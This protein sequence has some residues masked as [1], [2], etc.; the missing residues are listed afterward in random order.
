MWQ[1]QTHMDEYLVSR[2]LH[3]GLFNNNIFSRTN[4]TD[5]LNCIISYLNMQ[6]IF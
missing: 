4:S 2:S 3:F 5:E 1:L 6:L